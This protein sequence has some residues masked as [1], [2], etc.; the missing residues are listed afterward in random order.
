MVVV[1]APALTP[2]M[3]AAV[4]S[5]NDHLKAQGKGHSTHFRKSSLHCCDDVSQGK[6]EHMRCRGEQT[7]KPVEYFFCSGPCM[8]A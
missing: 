2:R 4:N 8:L 6:E 1:G 3:C 7:Q 5:F